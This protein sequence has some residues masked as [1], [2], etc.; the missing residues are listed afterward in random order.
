[1]SAT[2]SLL[3]GNGKNP[4]SHIDFTKFGSPPDDFIFNQDGNF[5]RI[6]K[7]TESDRLVI[8]N[9]MNGTRQNFL[10]S[11]PVNDPKDIRNCIIDRVI[12]VSKN[13]IIN[14]LKQQGAFDSKNKSNWSNFYTES[15]GG[16]K[17]DYSYSVLPLEFFSKG[18]SS[19]P[20]SKP[21]SVLFIPGGDNT[22]QNHM[23]FGN[24]LWATSGYTLGFSYS[25]LQI[26]AHAN[27]LINSKSNGYKPQWDSADDQKSII[28]DAN[29]SERNNFRA[30]IRK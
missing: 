1:V 30:L 18:V 11:D 14:M 25:T 7:T 23:N 4:F 29:Y 20:L 16:G 24:F 2:F 17:F 22:A 5:V 19:N 6:D 9:S 21:S 8:E 15:K 13:E 27:S 12:F 28:K 26:A 3:N 10:F